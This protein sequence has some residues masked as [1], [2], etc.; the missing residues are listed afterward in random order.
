MSYVSVL[1]SPRTVSLTDV[2]TCTLPGSEGWKEPWKRKEKKKIIS[3]FA[4]KKIDRLY[5]INLPFLPPTYL[6]KRNCWVNIKEAFR[7][8]EIHMIRRS[9]QAH[10][11][12]L[13]WE[14]KVRRRRHRNPQSRRQ[15]IVDSSNYI[16]LLAAEMIEFKCCCSWAKTTSSVQC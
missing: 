9:N 10:F 13:T 6:Q 1:A 15:R 4:K 12:I 16:G 3:G 8:N 5:S 14:S 11:D 2:P 7:T